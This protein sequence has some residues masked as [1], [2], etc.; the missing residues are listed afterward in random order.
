MGINVV[1]VSLFILKIF[2]IDTNIAATPIEEKG[3]VFFTLT[4]YHIILIDTK[5]DVAIKKC[6]LETDYDLDRRSRGS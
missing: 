6:S 2:N 3:T 4:H 1:L 5:S